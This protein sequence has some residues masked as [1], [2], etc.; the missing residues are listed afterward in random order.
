MKKVYLKWIIPAVLALVAIAVILFFVFKAKTSVEAVAAAKKNIDDA[1]AEID[2]EK[3]TLTPAQYATIASKLYRAM[4]GVGT[5]EDAI[6]DAIS[7]LNTRSDLMYV[8]TVFGSK[9]GMTLS[10]WIA[11]ELSSSEIAH[12]NSILISKGINYTF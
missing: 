5:D 3:I 11:D 1:N 10:E 2:T 4:K 6:Y 12:L 8:I 7:M 9:D